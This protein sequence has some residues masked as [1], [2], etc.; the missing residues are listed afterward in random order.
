MERLKIENRINEQIRVPSVRLV[1][2]SGEQLGIVPTYY[3]K[4]LSQELDLDLVEINSNSNPPVCKIM[5][6][7]KYKF[8]QEKREKENKQTVLKMKEITFHPNIADHDY[9][10]RLKQ[11]KEFLQH[12]NRVKANVVYRGREIN[13]I[14]NGKTILN[15]FIEDLVGIGIVEGNL[16]LDGKVLSVIMRK[17]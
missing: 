1:G 4:Q 17:V 7:G 2:N 9:S 12:G 3:A 10:Y 5:D 6:F 15:R 11:A 13:Y 14:Q 8:Q 16:N